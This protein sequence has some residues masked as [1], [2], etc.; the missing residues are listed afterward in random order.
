MHVC[1][2]IQKV[3]SS[4]TDTTW[5]IPAGCSMSVCDLEL[6]FLFV[7]INCLENNIKVRLKV[8]LLR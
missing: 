3:E 8:R 2:K 6:L 1:Y 7:D 5:G 4:D